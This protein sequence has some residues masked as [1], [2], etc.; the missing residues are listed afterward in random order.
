MS[1][2]HHRYW[3]T[4]SSFAGVVFGATHSYGRIRFYPQGEE[5]KTQEVDVGPGYAY[6]YNTEASL[7]RA[8]LRWFD[9]NAPDL[10]VMTLGDI[11]VVDPQQIIR[12]KPRD[13]LAAA[14]DLWR[15]FEKLNGWG[16]PRDQHPRVQV[17]CDEWEALLKPGKE[18]S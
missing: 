10:S 16:A 8:A 6:R 3:L 9:K 15:K 14:N 7:R 11:G 2:W 17:L 18:P 4:V 12:A 13:V 1:C 5:G